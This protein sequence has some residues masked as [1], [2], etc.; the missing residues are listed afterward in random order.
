[1]QYEAVGENLVGAPQWR[2]PKPDTNSRVLC[3]LLTHLDTVPIADALVEDR[4]AE[5]REDRP[6]RQQSAEFRGLMGRRPVSEGQVE[7]NERP[8]ARVRG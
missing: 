7:R 6:P 4:L 8:S 5:V 2:V 3:S 1:M